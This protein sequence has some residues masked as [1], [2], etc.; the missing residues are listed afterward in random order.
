MK[1]LTVSAARKRFGALLDAVQQEPVLVCRKNGDKVVI[2]SAERY[3]QIYGITSFE[4]EPAK[5]S[6]IRT[7]ALK[8]R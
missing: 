1:T 8:S 7:N 6:R 2:I 5:P 4:S 3:K